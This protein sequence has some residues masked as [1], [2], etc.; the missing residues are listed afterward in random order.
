[1]QIAIISDVHENLANLQK[2]IDYCQNQGIKVMI[3]CGDYGSE[4]V[5]ETLSKF[6]GDFYGC[7]GNMDHFKNYF[8]DLR[9]RYNN[10]VLWQDVGEKVFDN[11]SL[12]FVH[13]PEEAKALVHPPEEF[14]RAEYSYIFYGHTHKPWEEVIDGVHLVNPGN[15]SGNP[16][17]ATFAVFNTDS[18]QLELIIIDSLN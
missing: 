1:M 9:A 18:R 6:S 2:V 16:Y 12:A 5:L 15:V 17:Q 13:K 14:D 11:I 7:L 10:L 4:A 3:G 8:E